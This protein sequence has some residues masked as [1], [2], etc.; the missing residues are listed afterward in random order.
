MPLRIA[1]NPTKA[2]SYNLARVDRESTK[3]RNPATN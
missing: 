1:A 3:K 2:Y